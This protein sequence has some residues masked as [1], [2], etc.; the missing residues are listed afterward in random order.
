MVE[1]LNGNISLQQY[2][3]TYIWAPLNMSSCT[4]RINERPDLKDKCLKMMTRQG[5]NHPVYGTAMSPHGCLVPADDDDPCSST[6]IGCCSKI[7]E[8]PDDHPDSMSQYK[9]EIDDFGGSGAYCSGPD[10]AKLL[11]ALCSRSSETIL[12]SPCIIN[13]MFTPQLSAPAQ[14]RLRS[15]FSIKEINNIFGHGLPRTIAPFPLDFGFGGL[16]VLEDVPSSASLAS[17][18]SSSW[19]GSPCNS[20]IAESYGAFSDSVPRTRRRK[21][22]M[23]WSGLPNLYWWMDR[24]SGV[25]GIYASQLLPQGDLQSLEWFAKWEEEV[26]KR[27][28]ERG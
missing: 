25:S 3:E 2:M 4:F 26:Y 7:E 9:E 22:S 28:E 24:E 21:G 13:E 18:A 20:G 19:A 17:E 11:A 8:L 6:G 15:F 5:L 14:S 23:F 27:I 10:F 1:R 12:L 16:L